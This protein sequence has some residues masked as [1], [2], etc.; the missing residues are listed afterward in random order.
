MK[1]LNSQ[2]QSY[3]RLQL[4]NDALMKKVGVNKLNAQKF[5]FYSKGFF[6]REL[7]TINY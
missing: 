7:L 2:Q 1:M 6:E 5:T 3:Q 4:H